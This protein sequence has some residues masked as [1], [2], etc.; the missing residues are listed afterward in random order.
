[1]MAIQLMMCRVL[2][3]NLQKLKKII[4]PRKN[5]NAEETQGK[6]AGMATTQD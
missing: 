5:D 4:K 1:M 3:K 2:Q 6:L